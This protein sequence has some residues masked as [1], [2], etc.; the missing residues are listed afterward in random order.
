[1]TRA[2]CLRECIERE[3]FEE[4]GLKNVEY[5]FL[6]LMH[7]NMAPGYFNPEWHEEYGGLY[8]ITLSPEALEE[9]EKYRT[10]KKELEKLAFYRD[11][12]GKEAIAAI[13]EVLLGY[14][15]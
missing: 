2:S 7:F 9:I 1:M 11:V 8:R 13:D 6:G 10:D 3:A 4:I 14:W 12:K 5:N 15:K